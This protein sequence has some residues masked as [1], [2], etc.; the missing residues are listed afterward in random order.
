MSCILRIA[1]CV[2]RIAYCVLRIAYCVLRIAYGTYDNKGD[3]RDA[4][5]SL[6][7]STPGK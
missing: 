4:H 2:L 5:A 7:S 6:F 3:L 1:Y